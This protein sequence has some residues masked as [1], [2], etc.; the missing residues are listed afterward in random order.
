MRIDSADNATMSVI[1]EACHEDQFQCKDGRCINKSWKC[2]GSPDCPD[3]S[4]E[5]PDCQA[6][7]CKAKQF[8][9]LLTHKCIPL[10]WICDGEED[11]GVQ[12]GEHQHMDTSD[13]DPQKCH[14]IASCPPNNFQC[15]ESIECRPIKALC[16]KN[17]DCPDGWD[18]G[19]FCRNTTMCEQAGCSYNCRQSPLGPICYCA[20]GQQ[21]NGTQC[22]DL[23]ECQIDGSCDQTCFNTKGSFNCSCVSGY[24]QEGPR[25][26]AINEPAGEAPSLLLLSQGQV[27]QL[28]RIT[29]DGQPLPGNTS[30]SEQHVLALDFDHRN[31]SVCF[32]HWVSNRAVLRC[33]DANNFS[34]S[35]D[36]PPPSMFSLESMTEIALDWVSGNWYFLDDGREMVFVCTSTLRHCLILLDVGL[37]KPRSIAL[38]PTKGFMFFTKWGA[39]TPMVERALLDGSQ[40]RT[41][42]DYKV[43]Y[44]YG[45]TVDFPNEHIYWVDAFLD[46]VERVNYDGSKRKTIKRGS[47]VQNLHDVVVFENSLFVA[48]WRDQ[49]IIELDKFV[50]KQSTFLLYGKGR[51]AM[52]KGIAM[53]QQPHRAGEVMIPITDLTRPTAL[54]YDVKTQFIYYSDVQRYTIE[55]QKV[56]GSLREKVLET[57]INNCEGVAVDWMGRNLYWT[58][59]GLMTIS[60]ARLDNVSMRKLL[61][62]GNMFHPRAIVVDP[63][64]GFMYW[65]D[66][67]N[68]ASQRGKI[69]RAWMDGTNRQ[70]FVEKNLHWPNGL[71]I[72]YTGKKLYW[73]DAYQD[74]IERIGLDGGHREVLFQGKQLDHPY[75]LAYYDNHLFWAEFQNGTVQKLNLQN[76]T[77][78]TLSVENPPL[79]EIRVFDNSSQT[80][81]NECSNN[82]GG[83]PELCLST[84]EGSE[85]ACRDGYASHFGPPHT[86]VIDVNYTQPSSCAPGQFQCEKNMRCIDTRYLC[87]GDD[88]CENVT[89]RA[90]QFRCDTNR[91]IAD[92][93]VCDGDRDCV[94]G[95]D[96]SPSQCHNA[97][98]VAGQFTCRVSGRCI[99]SLW[100]CDT[101]FDCSD[102]DH[103]D[104]ENCGDR[105]CDVY[106]FQCD[107]S[108]CVP[109]SQFMCVSDGT[110]MAMSVRC[111]GRLQCLDGSDEANCT[112]QAST[113]RPSSGR[114]KP[115]PP[116]AKHVCE[117]HEFACRSGE[118]VRQ[119]FVCDGSADCLDGSD[120]MGCET[121]KKNCTGPNC[122]KKDC[123]KGGK[124]CPTSTETP[125]T[126]T[127][128][129]VCEHPSRLC[130]NGTLCIIVQQLCDK[131]FD[132]Q[133]RSDEGLRCGLVCYC[134][135]HLHLQTDGLTCLMA[136]PCEMWGTCSQGCTQLKKRYKCNCEPGYKLQPDGFTC[137]STDPAT[138]YVIFSNRHEVRG[139]D[140]QN[141]QMKALISSLKNTIALDFL[142]TNETDTIFWTDVID[143]KIYQGTLIA[144]THIEVVVQTGLATAEGLAV[145][146]IGLNLYWVESNLDQIEVAKL[147]GSFRRTLIA[148]DME[149]PRAIALDP[150]FGYLFWTD[151]DANGPRIERC[152]M[153]GEGRSL[154][155]RVDQVTDGAWPNGLTL[156]YVMRGHETQTHPFAIALF[157]NYV[158]WTDWRT[159][160]VVR[161]SKWNG[162]EV[163]VIQRTLTQPFDIQILHPTEVNPCGDNNG[164]CSH[165]C[166]L[167]FNQTYKCACPHVM[168]LAA[169]QKLC[170][171]N[172]TVLLFSRPNE[173]RGVD[174]SHPY[175]H[176]I[177][178]I[179]LPQ[180]LAPSQLDFH[181]KQKKIYWTDSQV[182]EVKRTN[183]T[184]SV[185][186]TVLD[187]A[188]E[189]PTGFAIDWISGNMFVA[190]SGGAFNQIMV[191][192]LEGEFVARVLTKDLSQVRSLALDPLRGDLFWS[193]YKD[194]K[195]VIEKS[196]MDGSDRQVIASQREHHEIS[197][198]QSL[199]MDLEGWRVYW[200]NAESNSVQYY[201][202]ERRELILVPLSH[203]AH[204]TAAVVYRDNLYYANQADAAIHVA[205]KTKGED[206][207]IL[208]NNTDNLCSVNK[209]NCSHLCLPVSPTQRVCM[210][211]TGFR[212]DP[213]DPTR[214][215]EQDLLY[216]VDSDHGSVTRIK[217]DGTGRQVVVEHHETVESIAIDWVTGNMYWTDPKFS[218]IEMARLNGSHRYVVV[219]GGVEKPMT[220]VLDPVAGM[221][222]WVDWGREP[223]IESA[224]L[225]GSNRRILVNE[226][227]TRVNDLALD[228]DARKLY[229]CDSTSNTIERINYDGTGREVLLDTSGLENPFA[230]TVYKGLI[231][232]IDTTHVHGS[233][234]QAPLTNLSDFTILQHGL[235]DSLKDIHVFSR[236]KQSGT[237]PC[238]KNNADCQELCLFNGTHPVCACAH[239]KVAADG[240]TCEDYDSF[241]MYSRVNRIDSIHMFDEFNLNAPFQNIQNKDLMRNAIGL[242]YDYARQTVFY[243]DIQRGSINSV[244][245]NGSN[246]RVIVERLAYEPSSNSIYWTCNNDA[247]INNIKLSSNTSINSVIVRLNSNDKPRG[248]AVDSCE[249][250][251]YWTNWDSLHPSIQRSNFHSIGVQSI[252]TTDI[253]MPNAITLDHKAQKLYWGDARL[254]KI[255][256]T[257]YDGTNRVVLAKVTPQHPFDMAVYGDFIF[258]TDWVMHAVIRANKHTGEDVVRLRSANPCR[259]LKGGCEDIC[260]LSSA[261]TVLCS[262]HEGRR[263]AADNKRCL[264][265]AASNCSADMFECSDGSC[266]P[267]VLTCD[268]VQHCADQS[269]EDAPYCGLRSCRDGYFQCQ[270]RRCVAE[271]KT[272][273]QVDDCGDGSDEKNCNCSEK[274]FRCRSGHCVIAH[275]RCDNDPDCPDANTK[276]I[277]CKFTTACIHP[278]WICDGENDCWDHSDEQNCSTTEAPVTTDQCPPG[279]FRCDS[280]ACIDLKWRCDRDN[281]CNDDFQ[282]SS[283]ERDCSYPC[284]PDHFQCQ[285]KECIPTTWQCD[286]T[287]DCNDGSDEGPDC[288]TRTCSQNQFRCNDTGR[289]IPNVWVCDGDEDC[290]DKSDEAPGA[291]CEQAQPCLTSDFHCL[292]HKCI[293]KEFF[294]DGEDDCDDG[295]DEPELCTQQGADSKCLARE[296][297]CGGETCIPV[298]MTCNGHDD[299]FDGSDEAETLCRNA[300]HHGCQE[301]TFKC[302]NDLCVNETLLC[303]G[304]D[305]CGDYSDETGCN[306]DEC[307]QPQLC[308]HE[309]VDKKVG[310]ECRCHAGYQ[311]HPKDPRLC[312]D[313]DEC[314]RNHPCSQKCRNTMGSYVCYCADDYVL[315]PNKHSCKANSTVEPKLIFSNRYYI[316]EIDLSGGVTLLANNLTNAV[317]LDYDWAENCVY[318]SDV[319]GLGSS[320]KRLCSNNNTYQVL[321]S[322]TLQNP[323][324]LAVDWVGRNLYWCDKGVDTIEVSRLDGRYRRVLIKNGLQ[325]PRAITLDPHHG[326]M[327]WTDWGDMPYIAK[328]GMDGTQRRTLITENLGWPNALTI[329]YETDELFWADAREDYI[330][331]SDLDGQKRRVDYLYWT[332]WETKSVERCH[333]YNGGDCRTIISTVHRPMDIHVYHPLRQ[334]P[335]PENPCKDNGNC[336]TLCLL[337]PGGG[338]KCACPE[339]FVLGRD[340]RSCESNCTSAQYE[341]ATTY[342]CIP[343]WWKCDTQDDCGDGSD[344]P[345]S[346]PKFECMPGQFQCDRSLCIHP[347]QLCNG[348][349]ECQDGSDEK[350]CDKYTCLSSYFKCPAD[351]NITDMC[352]PGSKRCDGHPDCAGKQDEH[353]CPPK[354]CP[355]SQFKCNNGKCIPSVWLCDRDDDCGD[356]SDETEPDCKTRRCPHD[357][358]RC[359]SGRCIPQTWHCDGDQDCL[360]GEDEPETCSSSMQQ[361]CQPTYF[362]CANNR[363]IPGRWKCDYD[364]D[365]GDNSDEVGC[366]P[367]NCSESEFRCQDGRCIRGIQQCDGE[368]NCEDHSDEMG[369]NT[370]CGHQE[371]QCHNPQFCISLEWECDGDR[372]CIDGSDELNCNET[373]PAD[374][375]TIFVLVLPWC[376]MEWTIAAMDPMKTIQHFH[377]RN[378]LCIDH[379]LRCDG[380]NNCGDGSDEEEDE[381]GSTSPCVFGKS[382]YLM[383]SSD[384]ELRRL[385]PYKT[386]DGG[387]PSQ[388]LDKHAFN[389]KI[390][391]VDVLYEDS[392][393]IAVFW[394][395]HHN[396][397]IQRYAL[398]PSAANGNAPRRVRREG[399]EIILYVVDAGTDEIL[400][401]TLDGKQ[402]RVLIGSDLDQP[403]D[404]KLDPESGWMFWSDWGVNA[405]IETARMDGSNR[406]TLV[407]RHV[408]WPTGLAID[409]PARR[410]YWTD[411]K[412]HTVSSVDLTGR[413]RQLE[414]TPRPGTEDTKHKTAIICQPATP[415]PSRGAP[416]CPLQCKKGNCVSTADGFKCVCQPLYE[417]ELCDKFRCSQFCKN[418]GMCFADLLSTLPDQ[419]PPLKCNCPS[420]WMGD[421]CETPVNLCEGRCYNGGGRC[422]HCSSLTC[423]HGGVCLQILDTLRCNCTDGFHGTH[424]ER[425]SCDNYC[426]QGNCTLEIDGPKCA[427]PQGFS[428][429][430]CEHD[431]CTNLCLNGGTCQA[432]P[433][434]QHCSCPLR[435][436][437]R[438]CETDICLGEGASSLNPLICTNTT[439]CLSITCRNGGTCVNIAGSPV[440]SCSSGFEGLRCESRV[441]AL[442]G[443]HTKDAASQGDVSSESSGSGALV[444]LLIT[445]IVLL[446]AGVAVAL[447]LLYRRRTRIG[448]PFAHV[449]M[450]DN[451]EITNPMYLREEDADDPLE[452]SFTLDSDKSSNFANPVYESMYSGSEA[453]SL[454]AIEEKKGLLPQP[455]KHKN[456]PG[457][458]SD[459]ADSA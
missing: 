378:G 37:N 415:A 270:N 239:G 398:P 458:T 346:C 304:Q 152:S 371:F 433:K 264:T 406:R 186:E 416:T 64:R 171:V 29:L 134:P 210:C 148:G 336:S 428:G 247:T 115:T 418:K 202:M 32:V 50:A 335:V 6:R 34:R 405:R 219:T 38:D 169:D 67:A 277:N 237:N 213:K 241:L 333:K 441:P 357:H 446:L 382:A 150:R 342:K 317:A 293:A 105:T 271:N 412:A 337:A 326:Y 144:L 79:F 124:G 370:T 181:A 33:A 272:C 82:N 306:V 296:F 27:T 445:G 31:G 207:R 130:D 163:T 329:S 341:C 238:A 320:I 179:S 300:T 414:V 278:N 157:E 190:S 117:D 404:I 447:L 19:D 227:V 195:Y 123:S 281:D 246:H 199:C 379:T 420:Q 242:T 126:A 386:T 285:S 388:L 348:Q 42:V 88:D 206:D 410:L 294:C 276:L 22:V 255:E 288:K 250:L 407:D 367:R 129:V 291:T 434:K 140:L 385:N 173:I 69:E 164:G 182:N 375:A 18:E 397:C 234:K 161:A 319:T 251:I 71:S 201:D 127:P 125:P 308:A 330:A 10:G 266:I 381:C 95:T 365:C 183:L 118:C 106:E 377:C 65:S 284:Q 99:P 366:L 204:P 97:T 101:D 146:W 63:K 440:C 172:E 159:N 419:P 411:P 252:I 131:R 2:D 142:H 260:R 310:Y 168:R 81:V 352:I 233:I 454:A 30:L 149:S 436:T 429:K 323:D 75:G 455:D 303:D 442:D 78:E 435:Y 158:Y 322:A 215:N 339:N 424:C 389:Y 189:N 86:C 355:A 121:K 193:D 229:W 58:D 409:Y 15:N 248:I 120:E 70:V 216:W 209:G 85:C 408:Q 21:P 361:L 188:I 321:H 394:T 287:P 93:W 77:L 222:F 453:A 324:G 345:K 110:C 51:P 103:T 401:V 269:D 9:C 422:E 318:W 340:G 457:T 448:K 166:L 40:R 273:D 344:E 220:I 305:N 217:R 283:D 369:C 84:P 153:S 358:F 393:P 290:S 432:G 307:Q 425:S 137:H 145:D 332:D 24:K 391:S 212:V 187:T 437:G 141:F 334:T 154:I 176:T 107:N 114:K 354:T 122:G 66:W 112:N 147:N 327:Y 200:V 450:Q 56:D 244:H 208:R 403:H 14:K 240:K 76:K 387:Q 402:R 11:C 135:D 231:F 297:H 261:G 311:V 203:A 312:T 331:V 325:E 373:C 175:Y 53:T 384:S 225:D 48:S 444:A 309:C 380:Q 132:C 362:K 36:L 59:E 87:D 41:L 111:D 155:I 431:A 396:K 143:D 197:S 282:P 395:D 44:P 275:F 259:S 230:I 295:S 364:N 151:W 170:I 262:C 267:Y 89:C 185:T 102:G 263:L 223:R 184:G 49:K 54:D 456:G 439:Q 119:T 274:D 20:Q 96:E 165:L 68:G 52:I 302:K 347:S 376:V 374:A 372:D 343:F 73:C 8:E 94:D 314:E 12:I 55:R 426:V 451:V 356:A 138:P 254:D 224:R 136:H 205:G 39:S 368:Y 211:A 226:S 232:W 160:S 243:S 298:E 390:E 174:L 191:C 214:C 279:K 46:F 459:G 104:E 35:W 198:P 316:R 177:P 301:G 449:R 57:G 156:D 256:R 221:L 109:V 328:A 353:E 43:V 116:P 133:D 258:W 427:C 162:S 83:C 235:G 299:C 192:N 61:V 98:C 417:G 5:P 72:D 430:K 45:V 292:N 400:V 17:P 280:G 196:K 194:E 265:A 218:V 139:V 286:G 268:S 91:C 359:N 228:Y 4:D 399:P 13:E 360:E 90:D 363:C 245:F 92:H 313:I 47:P 1:P 26:K 423:Q 315:R 74:K 350:D 236:A 413:D 60:V 178:T 23:D 113:K 289:C 25:C 351:G 349:A 180:V 128:G 62:Y 392:E 3:G 108:H 167:S 438:R 257:E 16:D 100:V 253:R 28:S 443:D 7:P 452:H 249:Q 383:V 80:G 421:R 338:A